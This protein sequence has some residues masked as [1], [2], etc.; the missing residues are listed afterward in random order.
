[1]KNR[2][3]FWI[4]GTYTI[5]EADQGEEECDMKTIRQAKEAA[6]LEYPKQYLDQNCIDSNIVYEQSVGGYKYAALQVDD[7]V[8]EE[9]L[10]LLNVLDATVRESQEKAK[11]AAEMEEA[12]R[13]RLLRELDE[14]NERQMKRGIGKALGSLVRMFLG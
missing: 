14:L 1:M 4:N 9:A 7:A 12:E 10:K 11:R 3:R 8:C 6:E 5:I 2:W 13:R